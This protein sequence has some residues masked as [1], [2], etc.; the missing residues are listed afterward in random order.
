M[1]KSQLYVTIAGGEDSFAEFK[2]DISQRSDFAREMIAFANTEGGY[3]I[4][5][6]EDD[7]AILGVSNPKQAEEAIDRKSVV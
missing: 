1:D 4:V 3:I 6:V 7:G 2:R 5:G